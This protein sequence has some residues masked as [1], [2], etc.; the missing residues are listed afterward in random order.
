MPSA[1]YL[2]ECFA[3]DN[4]TGVLTW[5]RRPREHFRTARGW[6]SFNSQIAG[7]T[8]GTPATGGYMVISLNKR[9]YKL[10]RVIFTIATG[11][12]PQR[13]VDH[14]DCNPSNNRP[15]NLRDA[16]PSQNQLNKR[17]WRRSISG[18]KCVYERNGRYV[19]RMRKPG[20]AAFTVG[21]FDTLSEARLAHAKAVQEYHGDWGRTDG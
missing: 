15:C 13:E 1:A 19:V 10:H 11:A 21:R 12:P 14:K 9:L 4:D 17:A 7:K 16:T 6:R 20:G 2:R 3:L 8:A 18:V 5:R